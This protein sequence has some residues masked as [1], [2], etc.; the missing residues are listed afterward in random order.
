LGDFG[1]TGRRKDDLE[2]GHLHEK[3]TG[4]EGVRS[5]LEEMD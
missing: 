5:R 4:S 3:S 1:G 2:G